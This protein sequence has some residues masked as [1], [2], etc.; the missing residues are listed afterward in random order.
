VTSHLTGQRFEVP[1]D[2]DKPRLLRID[3]NALVRAEE[4]SGLSFLD[5]NAELT[6]TRLKAL[7]WAS[8]VYEPGEKRLE[9]DEVGDVLNAK[10]LDVVTAIS[11]AWVDSMPEPKVVEAEE[12]PLKT[13]TA[14]S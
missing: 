9:Y 5:W 2:L 10:C 12:D 11:E 8:I 3:F 1:V 6:A 13:V 14:P 4:I 7:T